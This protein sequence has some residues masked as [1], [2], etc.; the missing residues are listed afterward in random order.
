V[1][2]SG[3]LENWI[4]IG[5]CVFFDEASLRNPNKRMTWILVEIDAKMGFLAEISIS[6]DDKSFIQ[7]MDYLREAFRCH[8][9]GN[10]GH[11]KKDCPGRRQMNLKSSEIDY[12]KAL[13]FE[14]SLVKVLGTAEESTS[15]FGIFYW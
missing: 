1:V 14:K 6:F 7:N 11:I 10:I 8:E 2:S 15:D 13:N 3:F 5:K 9:C 12:E 4:H